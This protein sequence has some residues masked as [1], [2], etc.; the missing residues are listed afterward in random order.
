GGVGGRGPG[1]GGPPQGGARAL[2]DALY[3]LYGDSL[4][5]MQPEAAG[6]GRPAPAAPPPPSRQPPSPSSRGTGRV[7]GPYAAAPPAPSGPRP[8]PPPA[9]PSVG[10]FSP[11]MAE[12]AAN[13]HGDQMIFFQLRYLL[14]A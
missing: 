9:Q 12:T 5:D 3:Q 1:R 11:P 4:R 7:P 14:A 6:N 10:A 13:P 2:P 8:S